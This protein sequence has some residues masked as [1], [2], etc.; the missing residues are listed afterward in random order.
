MRKLD[1]AIARLCALPPP[2][3]T[4]IIHKVLVWIESLI[5]RQLWQPPTDPVLLIR[6]NRWLRTSQR[7]WIFA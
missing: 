2:A 1:L 3:R 6:F 4:F 7:Q 5:W